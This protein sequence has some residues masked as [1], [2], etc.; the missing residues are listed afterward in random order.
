MPRARRQ[1]GFTLIEVIAVIVAMAV[2]VPVSVVALSDASRARASS[3]AVTRETFLASGVLEQLIA[4]SASDAPGLGYDAF[5]DANAYLNTPDTGLRARVNPLTEHSAALGFSWTLL[6]GDPVSADLT[7]TGEAEQDI[8]RY[9][10][11]RVEW[12]DARNGDRTLELGALVT[13]WE[14]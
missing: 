12:M 10:R 7:T 8:Y 1:R 6:V 14:G 2:V 5:E 4:D 3:L 11:V 9:V 13:D